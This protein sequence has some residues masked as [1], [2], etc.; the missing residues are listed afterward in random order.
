MVVAGSTDLGI[1]VTRYNPNGQPDRT[2]GAGGQAATDVGGNVPVTGVALQT[3]GKVV[4]G[5]T[6]SDRFTFDSEFALVRY[7]SDASLDTGFGTGGEVTTDPGPAFGQA[8]GAPPSPPASR[9]WG[10]GRPRQA[11]RSARPGVVR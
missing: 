9:S 4:V 11:Q 7:N 3:D 1:A 5:A 2:F 6:A 8:A 10:P